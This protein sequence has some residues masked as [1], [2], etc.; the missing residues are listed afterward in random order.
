MLT[1]PDWAQ[2]SIAALKRF[3]DELRSETHSTQHSEGSA[4]EE[5]QKQLDS[6]SGHLDQ[7]KNKWQEVWSNTASRDQINWFLDAGKS[8]LNIVDKIGLI[9]TAIG[10]GS[11]IK[12]ISNAAT[13]KQGILS[14]L[15]GWP[16]SKAQLMIINRPLITENYT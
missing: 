9:P 16:K 1:R 3:L 13:G 6:I 4:L 10:I 15:F 12:S 11:G 2:W 8:A 7:L 5:N 14:T